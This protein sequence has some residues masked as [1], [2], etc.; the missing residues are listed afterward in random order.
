MGGMIQC[1]GELTLKHEHPCFSCS[2]YGSHPAQVQ[3][4]SDL[5]ADALM[6]QCS[7]IT[8]LDRFSV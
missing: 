3:H 1:A 5:A 6:N 8:A 7:D 4:L 2:Y